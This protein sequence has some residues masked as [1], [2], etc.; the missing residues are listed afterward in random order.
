[1][2]RK[3]STPRAVPR[4]TEIIN[5]A[6]YYRSRTPFNKPHEKARILS[7]ETKRAVAPF[8]AGD[9][10]HI[11]GSQN[12]KPFVVTF[13]TDMTGT[14]GWG[15]EYL[16]HLKQWNGKG[17]FPFASSRLVHAKQQ[18]ASGKGRSR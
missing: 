11:K 17:M 16:V 10:V 3:T 15:N 6:D 18:A 8:K 1:M 7:F 12:W 2:K 4:S 5:L 14:L 13:V 9:L